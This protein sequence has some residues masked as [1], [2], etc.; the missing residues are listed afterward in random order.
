MD[1]SFTAL[2]RRWGRWSARQRRAVGPRTTFAEITQEKTKMI[3]RSLSKRV[4]N[5]EARLIPTKKPRFIQIRFVSSDGSVRD[6][7]LYR[8]GESNKVA[9]AAEELVRTSAKRR[10]QAL[11]DSV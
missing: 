1:W 8:I 6:G 10:A 3:N 11:C 2:K 9:T 4:Q 5:L 7:P